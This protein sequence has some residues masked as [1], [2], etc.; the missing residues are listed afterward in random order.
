MA[1]ATLVSIE[2]YLS[3]SWDPDREYVDGRLIERNVG[4]LDHSYLQ[5]IIYSAMQKRGLYSFVELR[6]QVRAN[7]FRIPDVAAVRGSRPSG[8]FL[9]QPPYIVV[10]ILSREDRAGDIDDKVDDYIELGVEN[11]WVVDPRRL[12]VTIRTREGSRICRDRVE[13]LDGEVLIPLAEIFEDMPSTE[14]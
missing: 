3:T 14:D 5:G 8:R 4:E 6:V 12:R 7:R 2:E 13:T 10:E 9:R 11:I 1:V